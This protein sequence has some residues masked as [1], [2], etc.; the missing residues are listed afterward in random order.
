MNQGHG[1]LTKIAAWAAVLALAIM[2]LALPIALAGRDLAQVI[3][4]PGS[5]AR[6]I[7]SSV[8]ESGMLADRLREDFISDRWIAALGSGGEP[9]RP[10]FE[11]LSHSEREEMLNLVLPEGWLPEQVDHVIRLFYAWVD[12]D[13]VF[14]DV[15][16]DLVPVKA[17]LLRGGIDAMV[18]ILI[19]SW[20]SCTDEEAA[21]LGQE[22]LRAG[23][24]P[25]SFC[26][27]SEPLRSQLALVAAASLQEQVDVIPDSIPLL[28]NAGAVEAAQAKEQLRFLRAALMW[29]WYLPLSLLGLV[30]ALV[31]RSR[32]DVRRW[33]GLPLLLSGAAT[34]TWAVVGSASRLRLARELSSGISSDGGLLQLTLQSAAQGILG[35]ALG[36]L[37]VQ[38]VLLLITGA[39]IWFG[40]KRLRGKEIAAPEPAGGQ[41]PESEIDAPPPVRPLREHAD[42]Q[43]APIDPPS[44]IFG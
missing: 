22:V 2:V 13:Q 23:R 34:F 40:V 29:G 30:M 18:E 7:S 33:W 5:L 36:M 10:I 17:H 24:L 6:V 44:G 26:E 16:L 20:P 12:S 37:Y 19:D 15:S 11:H 31:I 39:I 9:L 42:E 25:E 8:L 27:P 3:F 43:D 4:Q 38:A 35:E 28:E 32:E 1:C 21:H 14:P 41:A